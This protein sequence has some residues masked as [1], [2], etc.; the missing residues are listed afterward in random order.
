[1]TKTEIRKIA[2]CTDHTLLSVASTE[3]D[4]IRLA[5]DA[6]KYQTA[7]VCIPPVFVSATARY[8]NGRTLVGTVVGF[9]NGYSDSAVKVFEAERAAVMGADEIDMVINVGFVKSGR[10]DMQLDEIKCVRRAVPDK[11]L[12]VIIECCLLTDEEKIE[13][14]RVVSESGADYIKTSTGFSKGGATISDA[15]LLLERCAPHVKVKAAGG[16][17]TLEDAAQYIALGVSRIGSSAVV[18]CIKQLEREE[19]ENG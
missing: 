18:K 9:P 14:C 19:A 8:I 4:I 5:D 1:M 3:E 16:I 17:R 7:S 6:I 11:T 2:A 15:K 10:Y 13:M 12:K